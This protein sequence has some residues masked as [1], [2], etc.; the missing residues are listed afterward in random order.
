MSKGMQQ[1][2]GIAQALVGSPRLLMLDEPTSALDPVGRRVVRELLGEMRR[3]GVAVVLSSHLLSEVELVCDRV[4]ILV[5]GRIGASGTPAELARPR[6]VEVETGS[7]VRRFPK[8]SR[9]DV[10]RIVAELVSTGEQVYDVTLI[11]STLEDAY[12]EAV[13]AA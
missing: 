2:L 9:E 13:G 5:G 12:L 7:G 6:G 8:A 1:R 3:R 4:A 10:P 11:A